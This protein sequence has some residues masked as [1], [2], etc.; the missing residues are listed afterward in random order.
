MADYVEVAD[1]IDMPGLRLALTTG[2]PGPWG[3]SAKSIFHVKS[4]EYTRVRQSAGQANEALRAWTGRDNAPV[5]VYE[6]EPPRD[7]WAEILAL[8]ERLAPEPRLVPEDVGERVRMFGL[9]HEICGDDGF[10]WSRRLML[11]A[12]ML[13]SDL[14][15]EAKA[16]GVRMARKYGYSDAAVASATGRVI[17]TLQHLSNVLLAQRESGSRYFVGRSLTAL[18][19]Y[20]ACFA[21]L[22]QPLPADLCPMS[23]MLRRAYT[24]TDPDVRK[25]ADPILL[26][27][28]DY[29]YETYLELPLDF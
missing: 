6:D 18:D 15:D 14:P 21:A 2:V 9:A 13:S 4:I 16:P 17:E 23:H 7:G 29:I 12:P 24:V 25:A 5:A 28:R 26:E 11:L 10:A 22:Y 27:H 3:E 19:V 8:A 20:W 1:A